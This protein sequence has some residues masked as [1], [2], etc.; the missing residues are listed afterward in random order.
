MSV[1]EQLKLFTAEDGHGISKPKREVVVGWFKKWFY[2]DDKPVIEND[3]ALASR[4]ELTCTRAMQVNGEYKKEVDDFE[5]TL[6]VAKYYDQLRVSKK[7]SL[8]DTIQK[9]LMHAFFHVLFQKET[10]K[11]R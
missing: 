5:R 10:V 11:I 6:S 3:L 7:I 9:M 2:N 8:K 4:K 1:S